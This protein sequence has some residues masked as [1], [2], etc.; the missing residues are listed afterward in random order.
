M[1]HTLRQVVCVKGVIE[2]H[3]GS[4]VQVRGDSLVSPLA[5]E[6]HE[7]QE[8][9]DALTSMIP[10]SPDLNGIRPSS[11]NQFRLRDIKPLRW[12]RGR[13]PDGPDG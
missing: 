13:S 4:G 7:G 12:I 2:P 1:V 11:E 10:D 8:L 3:E 9:P 5:I 6:P